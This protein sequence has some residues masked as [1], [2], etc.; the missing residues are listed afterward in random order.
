M[1]VFSGLST[2]PRI[3]LVLRAWD[4]DEN[5]GWIENRETIKAV[6]SGIAQAIGLIPGVGTVTGLVLEG[7][8]TAIPAVIDAFVS[9]DKDDVLLNHFVSREMPPLTPHL[10]HYMPLKVMF[11]KQDPTGQSDYDYTLE[12]T[13][14]CQWLP[15]FE[16]GTPIGPAAEQPF[17]NS[18]LE[19]WVGAWEGR[20]VRADILVAEHPLYVQ[21]QDLRVTV[22]ER[23]DGQDVTTITERVS[24]SRLVIELFQPVAKPAGGNGSVSGFS[25]SPHL[26]QVQSHGPRVVSRQVLVGGAPNPLAVAPQEAAQAAKPEKPVS[27]LQ[28]KGDYLRLDSDA[29]LELY[30]LRHKGTVVGEALRYRRPTSTFLGVLASGTDVMLYRRPLAPH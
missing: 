29:S 16:G 27:S 9:W 21:P 1:Q 17:Q 7:A 24:I 30:Q 11:S 6:A 18:T 15:L 12:L 26:V 4:L 5:E 28:F 23:V 22:V 13:I 8:S 14:T 25:S 3:G 2:Q 20:G 10:P 19:S